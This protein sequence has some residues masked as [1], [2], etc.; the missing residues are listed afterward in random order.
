MQTG[1]RYN[2]YVE[3]ERKFSHLTEEEY[4]NLME[5]LSIEYYETGFPN[6]KNIR[7]EILRNY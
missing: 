2:I 1:E 4:F 5:D 7:T 3:N 6:P